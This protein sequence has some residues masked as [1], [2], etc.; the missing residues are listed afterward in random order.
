M[1]HR[2]Q[3][4]GFREAFEACDDGN[5]VSGDGCSEA[6]MFFKAVKETILNSQN[7]GLKANKEEKHILFILYITLRV[8]PSFIHP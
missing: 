5:A 8:Y 4:D 3:G 1:F 2:C 6:W 7:S